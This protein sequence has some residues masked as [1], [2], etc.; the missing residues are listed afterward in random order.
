MLIVSDIR[1]TQL[2]GVLLYMR[3]T[4]LF[5]MLMA[6]EGYV[7]IYGACTIL[8]GPNHNKCVPLYSNYIGMLIVYE[9]YVII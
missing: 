4:S 1:D 7:I 6:D 8:L 9:G 2:S 5:G 3:D